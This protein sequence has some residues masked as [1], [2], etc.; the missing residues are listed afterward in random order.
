M[1]QQPDGSG[2]RADART[3]DGDGSIKAS[4]TRLVASGREAAQAELEW[5]KLKGGLIAA[6]VR[7]GVILAGMA[8]F[9]L[10]SALVLALVAAVVALAK[11]VGLIY[12]CLI[13]AALA[14]FA[15][16]ILGLLAR[17]TLLGLMRGTK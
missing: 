7:T 16:L 1:N 11:L 13:I 12:A 15:G 6:T 10:M 8:L 3:G 17:R 4:F 14:L 9:G 2:H 5:A